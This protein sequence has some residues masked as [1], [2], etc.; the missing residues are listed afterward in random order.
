MLRIGW[1]SAVILA[2]LAVAW[3]AQSLT[4][5]PFLFVAD[6]SSGR[7]DGWRADDPSHWR[8]GREDG[9]LFYELTAPGTPGR[10][11]APAS[12]SVLEGRDVGAFVFSGRL[13]C[14]ADPANI[15]RDMDVIFYFKD[16]EHFAYVHFAAS[17]DDVHNIIGLV[18]GAD[19][20]KINLE[21]A[22]TSPARLTGRGWHAFKVTAD[23]AGRVEA[24]LDD[25]AAP[26]LTAR[27]SGGRRGLVG[28]GSFD[29]TGAFADLRLWGK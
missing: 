12:W 3:G 23:A 1:R 28:V 4:D 7:A 8:V 13:R 2:A 11:R 24:F 25:L 19:R 22:G 9:R 26:I 5:L 6:F 14:Q 21:P 18:D 10:F 17:S 27:L 16:P 20:I 29:D 15:R